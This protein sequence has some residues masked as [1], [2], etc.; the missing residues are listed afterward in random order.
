LFSRTG[1]GAQN[2]PIQN[3]KP[4]TNDRAIFLIAWLCALR[5][6]ELFG[7]RWGCYNGTHFVV[8][9]TAYQGELQRMKIKKRPH[10]GNVSQRVVP[11]PDAVRKAIEEWRSQTRNSAAES[12]MFPGTRARG[13]RDLP[14]PM[15][16]DNWLRLTLYPISDDLKIGFHPTFQVLRRSFSTHGQEEM[17]PKEMQAVL[18][19]EDIRTTMNIYT[20]TV[21]PKV[22]QRSN[23]VANRLLQL[24]APLASNRKQ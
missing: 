11:I 19:H 1:E 2:A 20:Q 17:R 16:P 18:G 7:P 9:N 12:L 10:N 21:D 23:E 22:M 14:N 6:S 13:R 3:G 15:F 24:D 5:P 4:R 8:I